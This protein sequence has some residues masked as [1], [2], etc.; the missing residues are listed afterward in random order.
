METFNLLAA[1]IGI[2][3]GFIAGALEGLFFYREDWRGGYAAWR[4]R[5]T[6]LAHISFFGIGF[7][8]LG[9][10]LSI[11]TFALPATFWSSRLLVM[12]AISMPLVCYLAAWKQPIRHLFFIPVVSLVLGVGLFLVQVLR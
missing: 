6:R 3:C 2:F 12:G 5:L 10:A 7:I 4:R 9:Y 1:W 8:N 11:R